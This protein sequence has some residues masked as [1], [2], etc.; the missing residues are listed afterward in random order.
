MSEEKSEKSELETGDRNMTQEMIRE[1]RD[2]NTQLKRQSFEAQKLIEEFR[3][4]QFQRDMD[5]EKFRHLEHMK[6]EGLK[7]LKPLGPNLVNKFLGRGAAIAAEMGGRSP[8]DL[9]AQGL[10]E[11]LDDDQKKMLEILN[12]LQV[13]SMS[14]E[15]SESQTGAVM[16]CDK[17]DLCRLTSSGWRLREIREETFQEMGLSYNTYEVINGCSTYTTKNGPPVVIN[18]SFF[19]LEHSRDEEMTRLREELA[20][21]QKESK[22]A[23][24]RMKEV[25]KLLFQ[26]DKRG[27]SF[28]SDLRVARADHKSEQEMRRAADTIRRKLEGDIGRLRKE[29]GD[30]RFREILAAEAAEEKK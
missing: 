5:I 16:V 11:S 2:E 10:L 25:E 28:E 13:T 6:E 20:A 23:V 26:A 3:S 9:M 15:K 1:L 24:A 29:I 19:V 18:R 27:N 8:A 4:F 22:E 12:P 7:L 17:N 21:V 30:A 14:E